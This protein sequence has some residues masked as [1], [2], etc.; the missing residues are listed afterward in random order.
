MA[1]VFAKLDHL[2]IEPL[3][4]ESDS[5]RLET[6]LLIDRVRK[7]AEVLRARWRKEK[8]IPDVAEEEIA[9][10]AGGLV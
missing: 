7:K 6:G 10:A 5:P 2:G 8:G 9:I 3:G 4:V 1:S